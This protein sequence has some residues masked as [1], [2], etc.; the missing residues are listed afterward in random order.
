MLGVP[1]HPITSAIA[2]RAGLIDG[3]TQAV[4]TRIP[5]ADLFIGV[6]ALELGFSVATAN[7]RHFRM[8][9]GL[10]VTEF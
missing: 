3:Q 5:L 10:T 7:V 4:G 1:L 9:P 6:T 8:I 2:L